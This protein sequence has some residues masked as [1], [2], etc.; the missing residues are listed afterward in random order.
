MV[1][2]YSVLLVEEVVE[3]GSLPAE[4]EEEVFS[5]T[6]EADVVV[7]LGSPAEAEEE[8]ISETVEEDV[9]A[10]PG[11]EPV[12]VTDAPE[13]DADDVALEL[14]EDCVKVLLV[15]AGIELPVIE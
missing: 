15:T 10:A 9:M 3:P 13:L 12:D 14:S 8:I 7:V 4:A 2:E 1:A 6:A 11:S 5:E